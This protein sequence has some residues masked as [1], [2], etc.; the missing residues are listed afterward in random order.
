MATQAFKTEE[1]ELQDGTTVLIKPFNIKN[2]RDF[3]KIINKL[4]E[5][6]EEEDGIEILFE[7]STLAIKRTNPE[8]AADKDKL[9]EV[10]DLPTMH[11]IIEVA[12]GVNL[13][14]PN[15]QLTA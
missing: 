4:K 12:G 14:D 13:N 1:I 3:F 7:A 15:L 5:L 10:L 8:L 6:K 2:L 11:K 9:E